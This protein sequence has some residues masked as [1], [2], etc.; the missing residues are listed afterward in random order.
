MSI[1]RLS[2]CSFR[3]PQEA[4]AVAEVLVDLRN[5]VSDPSW[6]RSHHLPVAFLTGPACWRLMIPCA[7]HLKEARRRTLQF[8]GDLGIVA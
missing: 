4:V 8:G 1:P 3:A 6:Q 7:D 2:L 5:G